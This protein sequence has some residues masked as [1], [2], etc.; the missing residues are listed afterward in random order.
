MSLI[1]D[2]PGGWTRDG[3]WEEFDQ[4]ERERLEIEMINERKEWKYR[5]RLQEEMAEDNMLNPDDEFQDDEGD[6]GEGQYLYPLH[7]LLTSKLKG[8]RTRRTTTRRSL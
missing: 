3:Q 7:L 6:M 5:M 1:P 4:Y 2:E 8:L